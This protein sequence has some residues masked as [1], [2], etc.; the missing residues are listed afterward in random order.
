MNNSVG[1][2][3]SSLDDQPIPAEVYYPSTLVQPTKPP[4]SYI[5]RANRYFNQLESKFTHYWFW[6]GKLPSYGPL[7]SRW[8]WPPDW[9]RLTG[10]QRDPTIRV[11]TVIRDAV[12]CICVNRS[13]VFSP[14]NPFVRSV[15]TFYY[16]SQGN[17]GKAIYIYEEFTFND[18]A[19]M[20][21]IEA[22]SIS[23]EGFD[24]LTQL[25]QSNRPWPDKP[26]G[27]TQ[28]DGVTDASEPDIAFTRL[29][30]VIPGLGLNHGEIAL[31]GDQMNEAAQQNATVKEFQREAGDFEGNVI[32]EV[33]QRQLEK[34]KRM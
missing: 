25:A 34:L 5:K 10:F 26:Q 7:V 16:G 2:E 11:D 6:H 9:Y 24:N 17:K 14:T 4:A 28:T 19:E 27:T 30:T 31:K 1:E 32:E 20:T 29:S 23:K 22:W 21:F 18:L 3:K 15:V 12:P 13:H 33:I 8:E